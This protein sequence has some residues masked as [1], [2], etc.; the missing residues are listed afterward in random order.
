MS[1]QIITVNGKLDLNRYS[2]K[3]ADPK[4]KKKLLETEGLKRVVPLDT[5]LGVDKLPF[6]MTVGAMLK[7]AYW[8]QNQMSYRRASDAICSVSMIETNPETVRL[9]ADHVGGVVFEEDMRRA[10]QLR[11]QF[12][13]SVVEFGEGTA[14]DGILYIQTDGAALNTRS[15]DDDGSTWRENKLGMVFSSD[16]IRHW[17]DAKGKRQHK[18]CKREYV[19]YVGSVDTFKWLLLSCAVR[20]G[21]GKYKETVFLGDGA[22]WIRNMVTELYPDA[23][24]ILD[25]FHLSENVYEFAKALFKMDESQYRP[26]AE[27][28]CEKLKASKYDEVLRDI[29]EYREA[30]PPNSNVNLYNYIENNIN[31]IDYAKYQ[32]DGYFIGSGAIE[33]GNRLVLQQRLK[34][35]GMRWN[36]DTAQPLLTLRAKCESGL[37]EKDVVDILK[38]K[39]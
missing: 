12:A 30:P 24:Q 11:D 25:F 36:E 4:S 7:T 18:I 22:T 6:K 37:W 3:P 1:K 28:L 19:S 8:A 39:Y 16:N 27:D 5:H 10:S 15:K 23:Q 20:N 35:P 29:W 26:W 33:S 31:N 17:T 38:K 9:V 34:Q 2:L 21:Y 32:K 13:S 14:K